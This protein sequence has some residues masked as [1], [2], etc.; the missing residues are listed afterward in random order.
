MTPSRW[1]MWTGLCVMLV[2]SC[3]AQGIEVT[4]PLPFSGD[5]TLEAKQEES[6]SQGSER[7]ELRLV[8]PK[9]APELAC[10]KRRGTLVIGM[11]NHDVPP[12]I[13]EDSQGNLIGIDVE[14][15]REMANELGVKVAFNRNASTFDEVVDMVA[16]RQAD[17]GISKL[18][19]T[20]ARAERVKFS[21]PYVSLNKAVFVNRL[22]LEKIR[23][24]PEESIESLMNRPSSSIGVEAGS[25]YVH[26]AKRIFP[27]ANI[28]EFNSW[29]KDIVPKVLKGE[30]LA[31]FRDEWAIRQSMYAAPKSYFENLSIIIKD[32]PDSLMI[33]VPWNSSQLLA[34]A[35]QF[36]QVKNI[37]F[38]S[39]GLMQKYQK[40][41]K[42]DPGKIQEEAR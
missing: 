30:L 20:L 4:S 39:D 37:K 14:I 23:K 2:F 32:E 29:D 16:N 12:F 28:I 41:I 1:L 18:S 25:S 24:N 33:I 40:M 21:D 13:M 42:S 10:I 9:D 7:T 15:A 17:L 34:W 11:L 5:I 38:T 26:Y 19:I 35:N 31:A 22:A 6:I 36:L 27:N 8:L 3:S